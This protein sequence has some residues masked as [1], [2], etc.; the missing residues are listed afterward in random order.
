MQK[1]VADMFSISPE[2]LAKIRELSK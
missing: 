2:A 1:L